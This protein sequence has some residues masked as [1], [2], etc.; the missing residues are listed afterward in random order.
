MCFLIY[1]IWTD[2]Q[3]IVSL[4]IRRSAIRDILVPDDQVII[5]DYIEEQEV[6]YFESIVEL[7]LEGIVAKKKGSKYS[8]GKCVDYWCKFKNR[9]TDNF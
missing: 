8:L 6:K 1:F 4:E 2:N 7:G 9:R 5:C 3:S